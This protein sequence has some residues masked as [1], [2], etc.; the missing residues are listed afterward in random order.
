MSLFAIQHLKLS[1]MKNERN[2]TTIAAV[3]IAVNI[4]LIFAVVMLFSQ[5]SRSTSE[6]LRELN[7]VTAT[8]DARLE[9]LEATGTE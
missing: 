3:L 8:I 6:Q 2:L 1:E 9:R 4:V 7:T 5:L